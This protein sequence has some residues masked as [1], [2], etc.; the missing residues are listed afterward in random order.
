MTNP[1]RI[2]EIIEA[3]TTHFVAGSYM[4][5]AAPP[6]GA[7][8]RANTRDDAIKIYGLVYN[9]STG[10]KEPGGKAT[11]RGQTYTG[12]QLYD[13]DIYHEY[14]DL[15]EVL[16]TEF[17]AMTVGFIRHNQVYH[18]LPP[19]PPTV[20][21]SVYECPT[22]ELLRFCATHDFF[23][24]VLFSPL[25]PGDELLAATI[26]AVAHARSDTPDYL[27]QAGRKIATLLKEDYD[28]LTEMLRRLQL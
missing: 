28:R 24:G 17:C 7:L 22:D 27:V 19:Q 20:H 3:S 21:Y 15:T 23:R 14:P 25:A 2:G 1:E 26:R 18:C 13:Q 9:I 10:S 16:Q 6:F 4:L 8:V 5:H 12:R 11:V